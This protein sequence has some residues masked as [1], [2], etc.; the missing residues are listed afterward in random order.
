MGDEDA[1]LQEA[2]LSMQY[3][4]NRLGL[5]AWDIKTKICRMHE[6]TGDTSF[7]SVHFRKLMETAVVEFLDPRDYD[8]NKL[9]GFDIDPEET[10]V[11]ELLHLVLLYCYVDTE[12][13]NALEI[14]IN[15]LARTLVQFRRG[16]R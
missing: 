15:R 5:Q 14:G 7:G 9:Y 12:T 3:W 13:D 1:R 10:L 16:I 6:M 4:K 8:A 2:I 11:H